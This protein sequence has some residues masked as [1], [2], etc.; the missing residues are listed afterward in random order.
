MRRLL[1]SIAAVTM[2]AGLL[3]AGPATATSHTPK[4]VDTSKLTKAVT[5]SG[6]VEHLRQLQVIADRHDGTRASGL[7]GHT[8][9][10]DYVASKLKKA[11]YTVTRQKFIFPFTRELEPATLTQLT[12]TQREVE[13]HTMDYSGTGDVTGPVIATNDVV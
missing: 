7:P 6:I 9:S 1:P 3:V 11:G 10:A 2:T 5:V 13:T 12:P 4:P 8:A